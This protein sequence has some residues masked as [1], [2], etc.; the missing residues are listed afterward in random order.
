MSGTDESERAS[1]SVS[2]RE[3]PV[4]P[5]DLSRAIRNGITGDLRRVRSFG[6]RPRIAASLGAFTCL[7]LS[8][9]IVKW[10]DGVHQITRAAALGALGWALVVS[11]V[12]CLGFLRF[13]ASRRLLFAVLAA[14]P[15]GFFTYLLAVSS[16]LLPLTSLLGDSSR[17]ESARA[18][19]VVALAV[20]GLCT[21]SVLFVWRRTDPFNPGLAGALL[22]LVGGIA[23]ATS[24]G[25]VCP[26]TEGWHLWIGHGLSVVVMC[27]LGAAIGRRLLSP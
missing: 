9:S 4:P 22:G 10:G 26:H 8:F 7:S 14:V 16:S 21:A 3:A 5:P 2:L 24:V 20:G 27:A 15:V 1:L 25:L 19:G 11:A 23:G 18:C 13:A 17:L 12:V 6:R